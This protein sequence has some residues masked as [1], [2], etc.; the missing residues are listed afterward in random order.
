MR[1]MTFNLRVQSLADLWNAWAWRKHRAATVFKRHL[2]DIAGTQEGLPRMLQDLDRALPDYRRIG[3][4][5]EVGG[6]GEHC[7]IFYRSASVCL[8]AHGQFWLSVTPSVPSKGW[9]A[10]CPRICTWGWFQEV[11][12]PE[13]EWLV[14]NTHLDHRSTCARRRG[15]EQIACEMQ[16]LARQHPQ[17]ALVLMG[18]WNAVSTDEAVRGLTTRSELPLVDAAQAAGCAPGPTFHGF[19]GPRRRP[20]LPEDA[21]AIDYIFVSEDV[22]VTGVTVD[23]APV[24]GRYPS[25]HYPLV[26]SIHQT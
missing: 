19:R 11:R 17:A 5:R 18:D 3:E 13:T 25:D 14:F 24:D 10:A 1:M 6:G 4:G 20:R 9:G 21:S 26:A 12:P 8:R 2:P 15:A 16:R 7:A 22:A 23:R